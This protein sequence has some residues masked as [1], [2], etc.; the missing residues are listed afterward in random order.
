MSRKRYSHDFKKQV[1]EEFERG[2]L[3][4]QALGRKHNVHPIS[5]YQ[6]AKKLREGTLQST[7]TKRERELEKKLAAT[8]RKV[9]QMSMKIDLLKKLLVDHS[10]S[11]RKF[12]SFRE[13]LSMAPSVAESAAK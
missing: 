12:A 9:G 8:E 10:Q 13:R 1:V 2:D 7:P 5:V 6:W 11:Q 3:T 4:A